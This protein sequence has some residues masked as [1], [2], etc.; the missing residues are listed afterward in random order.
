MVCCRVR[1]IK[2]NIFMYIFFGLLCHINL[3]KNTAVVTEQPI[4]Q[5]QL[6]SKESSPLINKE[7]GAPCLCCTIL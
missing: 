5:V 1:Y 7:E 6:N 2:V 4:G 3:Q